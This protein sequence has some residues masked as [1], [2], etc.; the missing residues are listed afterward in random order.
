MGKSV[1]V[2]VEGVG[3]MRSAFDRAIATIE[4]ATGRAVDES[5]DGIRDDAQDEVPVRTGTLKDGIQ[6][7]TD[8]GGLS[9]VVGVVGEASEY[10]PFVE[11]GTSRQPAKPYMTPASE[12]ERRRLPRRIREQV[13]GSMG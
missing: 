4:L 9:G 10:A 3:N 12:R 2:R 1:N 5:L 13:K 8:P 6:S 11:F 7:E